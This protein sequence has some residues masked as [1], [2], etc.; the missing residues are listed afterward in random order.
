[1]PEEIKV[2][3]WVSSLVTPQ[4]VVMICAGLV[5][6]VTFWIKSHEAWD[7]LNQLETEVEELRKS[8]AD[9]SD[10]KDLNER[11]LRQYA[12]QKDMNDKTNAHI[13]EVADWMHEQI[14]FQKGITNSKK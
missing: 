2:R 12:T 11:V 14:G 9:A 8:K 6:L 1:M 3:A 7:R 10:F 5:G 4:T 13:E